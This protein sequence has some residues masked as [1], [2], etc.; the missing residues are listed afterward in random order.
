MSYSCFAQL[1]IQRPGQNQGKEL[2]SQSSY[3]SHKGKNTT[4]KS[5]QENLE[6]DHPTQEDQ[7]RARMHHTP[8]KRKLY[9]ALITRQNRQKLWWDQRLY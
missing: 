7:S 4:C 1:L 6:G 3:T 5:G 2:G 8:H 9:M